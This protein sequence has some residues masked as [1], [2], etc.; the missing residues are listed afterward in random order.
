VP[1][2]AGGIAD[3]VVLLAR[4]PGRVDLAPAGGGGFGY[5]PIF[6]PDDADVTAAELDPAVKDALSHRR[7]A[8]D[9]LMPIVRARLL[10]A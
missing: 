1:D 10:G 4:W 7:Q 8:F 5:D 3:E 9:A 6:R 2:G